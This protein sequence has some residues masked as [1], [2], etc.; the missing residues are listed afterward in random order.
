VLGG[1][2]LT[3][4]NTQRVCLSERVKGAAL[5]VFVLAALA[6]VVPL[7]ILPIQRF[8]LHGPVIEARIR[9]DSEAGGRWRSPRSGTVEQTTFHFI[10]EMPDGSR[11]HIA[12]PERFP[13]GTEV[14]ISFTRG[15]ITGTMFVTAVREVDDRPSNGSGV[16]SEEPPPNSTR[17]SGGGPWFSTR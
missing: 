1:N 12:L 17:C 14:E 8:W 2:R 4:R 9:I 6:F 10:V 5:L 13:V 7:L 16:H 11:E 15:A 3:V